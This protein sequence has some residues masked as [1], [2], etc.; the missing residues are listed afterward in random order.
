M[1][2]T[3]GAQSNGED[4]V[5]Y[6]IHPCDEEEVTEERLSRLRSE[7]LAIVSKFSLDYLWHQDIFDIKEIIPANSNNSASKK[8][9]I[10]YL[11]GRVCVGDNVEDEWF[12]IGLLFELS[13][14]NPD[15]VIRV[16]D[17]DGEVLLI[18]A[19]EALPKWAQDPTAA[20]G[21]AFIHQG[22]VHLIPVAQHPGQLTPWPSA[23]PS[24]NQ[25]P[26]SVS[27]AANIVRR[28]AEVTRADD[29]IQKA[30]T[31]RLDQYPRDWSAFQHFSHYVMPLKAKL[32]LDKNPQFLAGAI[33]AFYQRDMI[34]VRCLRLMKNFSPKKLVKVG[35][36]ASKCLYSM[37]AGQQ[38][39]PDKRSGWPCGDLEKDRKAR[40]LGMKL[41]CGLEIMATNLLAKKMKAGGSDEQADS[42]F[43]GEKFAVYVKSLREKGYFQ[44][45][46]EGSKK[47]HELMS[48][49][50]SHFDFARNPDTIDS[51]FLEALNEV[52]SE[53]ESFDHRS[54]EDVL[55]ETRPSDDD[56]WMDFDSQSFDQ[57]LASHFNLKAAA[58]EASD[59]SLQR[60]EIPV[61]VKRFLSKVSDFEGAEIPGKGDTKEDDCVD[62]KV[63][64]FEKA[65]NKVL[66]LNNVDE[67]SDEES[68]EDDDEE[69]DMLDSDLV[70]APED[71]EIDAEMK[72]ELASS[73]VF[74]GENG[75]LEKNV[76]DL[77][78]LDKP[79]DIDATVLKNLLESFHSQEGALGPA[80]TLL[81]PMGID[82]ATTNN[83]L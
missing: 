51:R 2:A 68:D 11:S 49:A 1:A 9:S 53:A 66:N 80:A 24:G 83:D 52:E 71:A 73:K 62:F 79:L 7:C 61:E 67:E 6:T 50:K 69:I 25:Q 76:E 78:D 30:V 63:N 55:A 64:D 38:Y 57:M 58:T 41:T 12:V 37:L 45:E 39:K 59:H 72:R 31:S 77:D 48:K 29:V 35:L 34:D 22:R 60:E 18:E 27:Q 28:F 4:F 13:L 10:N 5:E 17:Q 47:Y 8:K 46:L 16:T 70:V 43:D 82:L 81:K 65:L 21:R 56:S 33:R 26:I 23:K 15:L 54:F 40:E 14:T 3:I 44:N 32:V 36:T 42:E 74:Q 19:A 20:E 75:D